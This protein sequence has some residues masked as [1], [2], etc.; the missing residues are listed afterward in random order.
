[1]VR[2]LPRSREPVLVQS[3]RYLYDPLG[4]V[5]ALSRRHGSVTGAHYFGVGRFAF[6]TRPE[7][8]RD[9][10]TDRERFGNWSGDGMLVPLIGPT[11]LILVDGAEHLRRRKFLLKPFHGE[12][13]AACRQDIVEIAAAELDRVP[14]GVPLAMRPVMQRITVS[15]ICRIVFGVHEPARLARLHDAIE[16][17]SSPR[18]ALP[19]MFPRLRIDLGRRSPWGRFVRVREELYGL[20]DETVAAARAAG[21]DGRDDVLSMLLAATDEAGRPAYNDAELR[22]ELLG[23]LFGGEDTTASA[24]AWACVLLADHP[25]AWARL[26]VEAHDGG[27]DWADAIGNEALRIRPSVIGA[28]RTVLADTELDGVLVPAGTRVVL[29]PLP[30]HNASAFPDPASFHPERWLESERPPA[31][32]SVPF[33]GGVH[34]CPGASLAALEMR[35]VLH[36][37]AR[38]AAWLRPARGRRDRSHGYSVVLVPSRG[39]RVVVGPPPTS[40]A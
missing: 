31:G 22:D 8:V 29:H 1:M 21:A 4:Q 33:G 10:L 24:L 37:L 18:F 26:V 32:A 40:T 35:E 20:L 5:A 14:R 2:T 19:L 27:D 38:R 36:E 3:V 16:R 15:V 25:E 9:A 7:L 13:L 34:R 28:A 23:L 17:W 30:S 39:G 6:I 12:R 11:A